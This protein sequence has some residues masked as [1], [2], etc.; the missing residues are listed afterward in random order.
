M[1]LLKLNMYFLLYLMI[2]EDKIIF[3]YFLID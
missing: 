3:W 1:I 2:L